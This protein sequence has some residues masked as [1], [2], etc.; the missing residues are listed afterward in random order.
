MSRVTAT[1]ELRVTTPAPLT[2][3]VPSIVGRVEEIVEPE[4]A[5]PLEVLPEPLL[6]PPVRVTAGGASRRKQGVSHGVLNVFLQ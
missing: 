1:E 5:P 4:E 2:N 6:I 3:W